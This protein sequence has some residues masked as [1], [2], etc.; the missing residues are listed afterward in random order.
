MFYCILALF[1]FVKVIL[2]YFIIIHN[3]ITFLFNRLSWSGDSEGTFQS[4]IQAAPVYH[5]RWRLYTVTFIAE[6]QAA[7][8]TTVNTNFYSV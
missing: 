5:T 3:T 2:G 6:G 8:K 4:S 1:F 7:R